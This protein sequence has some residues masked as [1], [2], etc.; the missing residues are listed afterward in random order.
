[1]EEEM[2]FPFEKPPLGLRPKHIAD[3]MRAREI[4]EALDRYVAVHKPVPVEWI[5]ELRSLVCE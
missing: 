1:M 2:S 5:D 3:A 4:L